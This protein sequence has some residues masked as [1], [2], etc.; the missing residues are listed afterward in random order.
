MYRKNISSIENHFENYVNLEDIDLPSLT[1]RLE[2]NVDDLISK[3]KA[4]N[5]RYKILI[6]AIHPRKPRGD[7]F[8][9]SAR[10]LS[11]TSPTAKGSRFAKHQKMHGK[12]R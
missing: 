1:K 5:D 10:C 11:L 3:T 6:K 12:D 8:S 7:L 9:T 2:D 4:Y